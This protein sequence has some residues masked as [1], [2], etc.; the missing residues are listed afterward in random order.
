M[1]SAHEIFSALVF[2]SS[3]RLYR[4]EGDAEL[5]ELIV[6]AWA[7]NEA[8]GKPWE[9]R[10]STLSTRSGL[11]IDAM[12]GKKLTLQ[13][14]LADGSLQPRSGIVTNAASECA[15]G[16]FAR[17]T[18][19]VRPWIALLAHTRQSRVWQEKPFTELIES[20]LARYQVGPAEFI[21]AP[22]VTTAA[23]GAT[24][25]AAVLVRTPSPLSL[26]ARLAASRRGTRPQPTRR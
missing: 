17:Y 23:H 2:D 10:I 20:V 19:T 1:P 22:R 24:D 13:S 15:D 11:D 3:T 14:V 6:E 26:P 5:S 4:L 8:L 21:Q 7:C 16:G 18:L 9:L 12:L 25:G